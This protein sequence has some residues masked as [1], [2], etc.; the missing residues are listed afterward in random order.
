M[1]TIELVTH[2]V[3]E[4]RLGD[5]VDTVFTSGQQPHLWSGQKK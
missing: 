3:V 5:E 2:L 4:P 1:D